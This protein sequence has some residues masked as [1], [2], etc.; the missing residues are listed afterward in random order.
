MS[1]RNV[2]SLAGL[3]GA[4]LAATAAASPWSY[5]LEN[6]TRLEY[7]GVH[8]NP[9]SS[10]YLYRNV[11]AYD[12]LRGQFQRK[13]SPY[14]QLSGDFGLL[15]NDSAYRSSAQ[16]GSVERLRF[17]WEKGD[18]DIPFRVQAGDIYPFLS[19]RTLQRPLKGGV[20]EWQPVADGGSRQS[21][22]MYSGAG[23]DTYRD[24]HLFQDLYTGFSWLRE[25]AGGGSV[26]V[27][28]V[29]N[30]RSED[31]G[32]AI[33]APGR[34]QRLA[35]VA[36]THRFEPAAGHRLNVEGEVAGFSG[37]YLDGSTLRRDNSGMGWFGQLRGETGTPLSY[38]LRYEKYDRDYRPNGS[39]ITPDHE[40]YE[41]HANWRLAEGRQIRGRLQHFRDGM[42][43]GDGHDNR[44][45]G[46]AMTGP[47]RVGGVLPVS[48]DFDAFLQED[49]SV[50]TQA[51]TRTQSARI[52]L[53][54]PWGS[55]AGRIGASA[56]NIGESQPSA[57]SVTQKYELNLG[58]THRYELS[59]F[60]G[61]ISPGLVWRR[62][63]IISGGSDAY[64]LSLGLQL[65]RAAHQVGF[66]ASLLRLDGSGSSTSN[67][68][69]AL[70]ANYRYVRGPHAFGVEAEFNRLDPSGG[71]ST[72]SY[73]FGVFYTLRLDKVA[74]VAPRPGRGPAAETAASAPAPALA[75]SLVGRP[76]A[77]VTRQLQ[78]QGIGGAQ[79]LPGALVFDARLLDELSQRQRLA[80]VHGEGEVRKSVLI[81]DFDDPSNFQMV[82]Q[83]YEQA[84]ALL[85]ARFGRPVRSLDRGEFSANFAQ[86]LMAGRLV[87]AEEWSTPAG[88]IRFG[89]P[90]R[91][92]RQV[93]MELHSGGSPINPDESYW[94]LEEVR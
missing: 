81:V 15:M 63:N 25:N 28:F 35:S 86:D 77:D 45:A 32:T 59:G 2:S 6:T 12:E 88:P 66:S 46:V 50:L 21:L 9:A 92:D 8:G 61:S 47:L 19:L 64:G 58:G 4:L 78:A 7:Y 83:T 76:L 54:M 42:E 94:G 85:V 39:G 73:R 67:F 37:D 29:Q 18:G 22:L 91:L 14:E 43:S 82:R 80:L 38:R 65:A 53:G 69:G 55:W 62:T 36:G 26:A 87:R 11:Q 52:N 79:A 90:Q 30:D 75:P 93:R 84:R 56:A 34:R 72:D 1:S 51:R 70:S 71:L 17:Q 48:L 40:A 3:A 13:L 44:V 20:V 27:N 16:G 89:I 5:N 68:T 60:K 57:A 24:L 31:V 74:D 33:A 49:E 41:V 10:P 23:H